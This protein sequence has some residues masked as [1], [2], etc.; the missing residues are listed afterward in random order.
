MSLSIEL[1]WY[2][3]QTV[4]CT[5]RNNRS[6]LKQTPSRIDVVSLMSIFWLY[7][8]LKLSFEH[9]SVRKNLLLSAH[10][11]WDSRFSLCEMDQ[12]FKFGGTIGYGNSYSEILFR[13]FNLFRLHAMLHQAAGAVRAHSGIGPGCCY[14]IRW[15]PISCLLTHVTGL[16]LRRTLFTL[17]FQLCRLFNHYVVHFTRYWVCRC[18][19]WGELGVFLTAKFRD[20]LFVQENITNPQ[21]NRFGA[22]ETR[23]EMCKTVDIWITVSFQ[24]LFLEM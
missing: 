10:F 14:M 2:M 18:S 15:G 20:T 24:T 12:K 13:H 6:W 11:C 22:Q 16:L 8:G 5:G 21:N 9:S 4:H 17:L 3:L 1:H 7:S 19:F 23:M